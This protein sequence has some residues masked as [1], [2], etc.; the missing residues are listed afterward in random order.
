MPSV[1][2]DRRQEPLGAPVEVP[3]RS[4]RRRLR[5]NPATRHPYRL[6][7]F[8]LG[9]GFVA[10]GIALAVLPGPLTIP[11]MLLGVWIWSTEFR[12][13]ERFFEI[14]RAKAREAWAHAKSHPRSSV[15]ATAGGLVIAAVAI[16]AVGEL[17][18]V[19]EAR[20]TFGV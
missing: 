9:L 3:R 15:T 18:L 12:W 8:A 4:L 6:A 10:L 5:E 2:R 7:V 11:P 13:A 16:W 20:A 17:G 19:D 1:Q 14:A